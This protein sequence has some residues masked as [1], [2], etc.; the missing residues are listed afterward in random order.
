MFG[1]QA[2]VLSVL[3]TAAIGGA[4]TFVVGVKKYA[5]GKADDRQRSDL[6]IATMLNE[7]RAAL[8]EANALV[9]ALNEKMRLARQGAE[10]AQELERAASRATLAAVNADRAGLR[11]Q[12]AAAASG[13]VEA[14]N[15]TVAACRERAAALGNVL[16]SALQAHA[17][18]TAEAE[19]LA[20]GVRAL[21]SAWPVGEPA[22]AVDHSP[23]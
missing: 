5:Q 4:S 13:G 8:V 19:D 6:V 11:Q 22:S 14:S 2:L 16:D 18:C 10:R 3:V 12:L 9:D 17:V 21:R 15:D 20:S 23:L 1:V 7:H